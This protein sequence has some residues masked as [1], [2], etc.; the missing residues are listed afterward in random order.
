MAFTV[1]VGEADF[2][3][4]R[5]ENAYYVDKT[6]IMYELVHDTNNK[7]NKYQNE[8]GMTY[9]GLAALYKYNKKK[10]FYLS[11]Y[12][13]IVDNFKEDRIFWNLSGH[14]HS[15]NKFEFGQYSIYNVAMD[16]HNCTPV[17]IE[18]IIKDIKEYKEKNI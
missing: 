9:I 16:A 18:Q 15:P 10:M 12:P 2:A 11:H 1:S 7:V 13:T 8:Y 5:N 14:T 3:A 6:E 17:S 4:L